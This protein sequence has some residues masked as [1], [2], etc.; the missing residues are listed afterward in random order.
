MKS[1]LLALIF[2]M[3]IPSVSS[4][5]GRTDKLLWDCNG[6]HKNEVLKSMRMM[7]CAGYRDGIV[8]FQEV[9]RIIFPKARLFCPPKSGISVDQ[10]RR[11]FIKWAKNHPEKLHKSARV[12]VAIAMKNAFPCK[13]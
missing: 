4:A 12:S 9:I 11:V 2:I 6:M 3:T 5:A 1:M 8:D 10:A 7:S 13:Q